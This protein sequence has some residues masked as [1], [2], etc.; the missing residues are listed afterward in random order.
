MRL[1]VRESSDD[2]GLD[3][4]GAD[5]LTITKLSSA[6][7]ARAARDGN[8][9]DSLALFRPV[10]VVQVVEIAGQAAVEGLVSAESQQVVIA[11]GETAGVDG[12]SLRRTI[13]LE[14]GVGGNVAS[15]VF[16]VVQGLAGKRQ[17]ENTVGTALSTL[18]WGLSVPCKKDDSVHGHVQ[19]T[20][21]SL[22]W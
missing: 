1:A 16:R 19:N 13:E 15:T 5:D 3:N 20:S 7:T 2:G 12:A 11:D 8:N 9:G 6:V 4:G 10:L 21:T 18:L 14:L 17:D 22:F